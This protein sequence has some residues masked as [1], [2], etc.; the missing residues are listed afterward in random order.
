[1]HRSGVGRALYTSLF[2]LLRLQGYCRAYA[3]ITLPNAG[4]RRSAR[5]VRL[6]HRSATTATSGHKL[7]AW[8]DTG[9]WELELTPLPQ[10]PEEPISMATAQRMSEWR[11]ALEAGQLL[12][13][14]RAAR[15]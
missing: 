12:L 1:M 15:R 4:Q 10:R 5:V 13:D 11:S 6:Q 7:G 3:G 9:W 2:A 14:R 8:H